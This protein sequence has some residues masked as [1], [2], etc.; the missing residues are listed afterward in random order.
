[1]R[2]LRD[3]LDAA[4]RLAAGGAE[5]VLATV[6]R[7]E[8]STYRRPGARLLV[9]PNGAW[10]G[11]VSGGCLEGD[12]VRK[13]W[14]RTEHGPVVVAYDSTADADTAWRL[15]LGCNG[16][17]HVLLERVGAGR[18]DPLGVVRECWRQ[19]T[20]G[21]LATVV[22]ANAA[23]GLTTGERFT[24]SDAPDELRIIAAESLELDQSRTSTVQFPGGEAEVFFEVIRP[25]IRLAI[26]GAGFDALPLVGAAQALGWH[27]TVASKRPGTIRA[28]EIIALPP[29][30]AC[31][32]ILRIAGL[33]A[34]KNTSSESS[35]TSPLKVCLPLPRHR[36]TTESSSA[37]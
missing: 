22:W 13:G 33:A 37:F 11:G 3:V 31:E 20:P 6:V 12:L 23:T 18:P 21:V 36:S 16:V 5:G 14:W 24:L 25:P 27:V 8:G 7:V 35:S 28:D 2:E 19:R 29:E 15:G 32:R 4:G 26:F 10:V 9:G 30:A 17:V 34:M 1:M